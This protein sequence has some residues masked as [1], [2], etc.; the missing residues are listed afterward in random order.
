MTGPAGCGGS[1]PSSSVGDD[2]ALLAINLGLV[3]AEPLGQLGQ[4][5]A[6]H[7]LDVLAG[8]GADGLLVTTHVG[9][10][11]DEGV[12]KALLL[13]VLGA[14]LGH[15]PVIANAGQ[16]LPE[17]LAAVPAFVPAH[18]DHDV[19]LVA[20]NRAVAVRRG[21]GAVAVQP[22][23]DAAALA[24]VWLGQELGSQTVALGV[25]RGLQQP[26]AGKVED[27]HQSLSA[28]GLGAPFARWMRVRSQ[29]MPLASTFAHCAAVRRM[30]RCSS[31]SSG[32][33]GGRPRPRFR[34]S[35]LGSVVELSNH[36]K[37]LALRYLMNHNKY[38]DK[39]QP[40]S[41]MNTIQ[42]AKRFD[43]RA[44][45]FLTGRKV[46][47]PMEDRKVCDCCHQ[48]IV[49]GFF[50]NLGTVGDD[51]YEV[52]HAAARKESLEVFLSD[53]KR[54]TGWGVKPVVGRFL[55]SQVYA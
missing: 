24:G 44:V 54:S 20:S 15:P 38:I 9:L 34:S 14:A 28:A 55:Q 53:L 35:M 46:S 11:A 16:R 10:D 29:G 3:Q 5:A 1:T 36:K 23:D 47:P 45:D 13:D 39:Q 4:V 33:V 22:A 43:D 52:I 40:E 42:T 27:V 18:V 19:N 48:R 21:M 12:K 49:K 8:Q 51:C 26:P 37:E 50:T 6:V 7:M 31:R 25:Q 30:E 41:T 32:G 17:G 2:Q